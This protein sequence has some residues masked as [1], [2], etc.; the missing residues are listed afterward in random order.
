MSE[1][2]NHQFNMEILLKGQELFLIQDRIKITEEALRQI[3]NQDSTLG[4]AL[5]SSTFPFFLPWANH[6]FQLS[7]LKKMKD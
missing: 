6:V 1:V 7:I 4:F 2:I 5:R 3:E